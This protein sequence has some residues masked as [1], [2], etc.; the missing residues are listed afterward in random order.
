[1]LLSQEDQDKLDQTIQSVAAAYSIYMIGRSLGRADTGRAA[2][3]ADEVRIATLAGMDATQQAY[4]AGKIAG[5]VGPKAL[6]DMGYP[7]LEAWVKDHTL[8]LNEADQAALKGRQAET[9]RWI[10]GNVDKWT[11]ASNRV[12]SDYDKEWLEKVATAPE[13]TELGELDDDRKQLLA[14]MLEDLNGATDDFSANL[15]RL[16]VTELKS[17]FE[18]GQIADLSGDTWVWK[19]PAATACENCLEIYCHPDGSPRKFRLSEIIGNSN[20]GSR[21]EQWTFCFGATHPSCQCILFT[22]D[23]EQ[24]GTLPDEALAKA[25]AA[26]V[27][28][29]LF[30]ETVELKT[31]FAPL[32]KSETSEPLKYMLF[33][34]HEIY[35]S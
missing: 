15:T 34:V 17:Y 28:K 30:T 11:A 4:I 31:I 21:P 32:R 3:V 2:Q 7:E 9:E 18:M 20:I 1:M 6:I 25:Y 8:I 19:V 5:I 24:D 26:A 22:S 35:G 16:F 14:D 33:K 10:E 12:L 29:A 13:G 27:G 23:D